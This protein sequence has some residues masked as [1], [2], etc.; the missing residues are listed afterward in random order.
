M[1]V[2]VPPSK[3][4]SE[5]LSAHDDPTRNSGGRSWEQVAIRHQLQMTLAIIASP[6]DET[7]PKKATHF[8]AD[9]IHSLTSP[10]ISIPPHL[11]Q[12]ATRVWGSGG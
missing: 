4:K 9:A 6:Y 5:S 11:S 3:L 7:E 2:Q 12:I 8:E 10:E 1:R